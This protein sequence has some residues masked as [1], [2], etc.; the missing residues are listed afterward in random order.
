[1]PASMVD[2]RFKDETLPTSWCAGC[3]IGAVAS[4]FIEAVR[5]AG[6]A[7]N[8]LILYSGI[9]CASRI[10]EV[11]NF[12]NRTAADSLFISTIAVDREKNADRKAVVFL[13]NADIMYSGLSDWDGLGTS[14][15][16][17]FIHMNSLLF[18]ESE[19]RMYT[20]TPFIR[21]TADHGD[22]PFNMPAVAISHGARFVA[23]WTPLRIGWLKYSIIDALS[24]EGFSYIEVLTPCVVFKTRSNM[25]RS[26]A[27]RILFYDHITKFNDQLDY[28][29]LDLRNPDKILVGLFVNK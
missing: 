4:T 15:D 16:I 1:M 17:L 9:G 14:S 29:V 25:I 22:L 20:N 12:D 13:D 7:D 6:L 24:K 18:I 28:N 2:Q 27:D 19:N 3:G 8:S 11:L 5:E 21:R 10:P 23:R 26:A